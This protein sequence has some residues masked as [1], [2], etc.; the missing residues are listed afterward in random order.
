[1]VKVKNAPEIAMR[2]QPSHWNTKQAPLRT[3]MV[4]ISEVIMRNAFLAAVQN[5]VDWMATSIYAVLLMKARN[6]S[7]HVTQHIWEEHNAGVQGSSSARADGKRAS[8]RGDC[9]ASEVEIVWW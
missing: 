1:M 9:G 2:A 8:E 3:A 5:D 7:K 4:E 6:R